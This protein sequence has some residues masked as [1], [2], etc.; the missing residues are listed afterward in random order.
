MC[1]ARPSQEVKCW[2]CRQVGFALADQ[3]ECQIGPVDL[4]QVDPDYRIQRLAHVEGQG[5]PA[6]VTRCGK[7]IGRR[8]AGLLQPRQ[9]RRDPLVALRHLGLVDVVQLKSL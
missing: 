5:R 9:N 6:L 1:G 7:G 2:P 8:G 3:F 4:R